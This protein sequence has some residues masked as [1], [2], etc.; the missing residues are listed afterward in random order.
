M[1]HTPFFHTRF[2]LH[3][4]AIL[5]VGMGSLSFA[6]WGITTFIPKQ[7]IVVDVVLKDSNTHKLAIVDAYSG[8]Y[9]TLDYPVDSSFVEDFSS[10]GRR[11]LLVSR[12]YNLVVWDIF[13]GFVAHPPKNTCPTGV[14]SERPSH[15][16]DY[17]NVYF[18]CNSESSYL[19]NVETHQTTL[20]YPFIERN[21]WGEISFTRLSSDNQKIMY[22]NFDQGIVKVKLLNE[23]DFTQVN[24]LGKVYY[25]VEW[26]RD[27]ESL[28]A[29]SGNTL[30]RYYLETKSWEI[31]ISNLEVPLDFSQVRLF[32]S[33][34]GQWVTFI[35]QDNKQAY[36]FNID[37]KTQVN[38]G[39]ASYDMEWSPDS[40]W[41]TIKRG[42]QPYII[43]PDMSEIIP[44]PHEK[45]F[46][47]IWSPD[48]TKIIYTISRDKEQQAFVWD[49]ETEEYPTTIYTQPHQ[50]WLAWSPDS[51]TVIFTTQSRQLIYM[52]ETGE[53]YQLL[54]DNFEVYSFGFVK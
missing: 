34:N 35:N 23:D 50:S 32:I 8:R 41:L 54:N 42:N 30:E 31:I 44:F 20:I 15:L 21:R 2:I 14:H 29:L 51:K 40:Q 13:T 49:F 7:L 6:T 43:R 46:S 53:K 16:V 11:I 1:T 10:N 24:P 28:L 38:L 48:S 3:L 27:N 33:P 18:I 9:M 37:T 4:M 47:F 25:N 39:V 52:A 12:S 17:Q 22:F 19:F 5:L 26:H 36:N 45:A